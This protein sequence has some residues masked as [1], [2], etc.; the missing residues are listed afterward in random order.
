MIWLRFG[1]TCKNYPTRIPNSSPSCCCTSVTK[2]VKCRYLG[3]REWYHRSAGVKMTKTKFWIWKRKFK[4]ER[5]NNLKNTKPRAAGHGECVSQAKYADRSQF[6]RGFLRR[7]AGGGREILFS[8]RRPFDPEAWTMCKTTFSCCRCSDL[9]DDQLMPLDIDLLECAQKQ[10]QQL[11]LSS[12]GRVN[13]I[14]TDRSISIWI[15][16]G[17][18]GAH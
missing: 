14:A 15:C 1:G 11:H 3:N 16:A 18:A 10:K 6:Q 13:C 5:K 9:Y 8:W 2:T 12:S 7:G 4:N 17:T